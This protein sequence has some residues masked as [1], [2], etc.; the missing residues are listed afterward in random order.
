MRT[1]RNGLGA[2]AGLAA[3]VFYV[4]LALAACS[5][6]PSLFS[7]AKNSLSDLRNNVTNQRKVLALLLTPRQAFGIAVFF[8]DCRPI[9][10]G[11]FCFAA[12]GVGI[13]AAFA[14][15]GTSR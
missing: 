13:K 5:Q 9:W 11:L 12:W 10:F 3:L 2:G 6:Y 7:P 8:R 15:K 1:T 4:G 14:A